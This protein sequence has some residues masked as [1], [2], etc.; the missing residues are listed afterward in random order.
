MKDPSRVRVTGPLGPYASG[1]RVELARQGYAPDSMAQRIQLVACLSRWMA[2]EKAAVSE[3]SPKL[4]ERFAAWRRAAGYGH[5]RSPQGLASLLAYLRALRAAPE[6]E[7]SRADG[8]IDVL[9]ERYRTYLLAERGL[10]VGTMRYYERFARLFLAQISA[11]G[12]GLDLARLTAGEVGRFVL[13]QGATRKVG[14]T[15]NMVMAVRSLLRFL[16]LDGVT[17]EDLEGAVPAVAPQPR[18]LPRAL[19]PGVVRR[20]LASCDRRTRTG[21]RDFAVLLVLTR[22]GL[23]AGEVA[24]IELEDIDWR[25][26]ELLVRSKGG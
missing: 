3:L 8:P 24:A 10:A 4:V 14:S 22:L 21:R 26:G 16:H 9:V 25:R 19:D 11:Q 18:P 20:L 12:R 1:F 7:V 23:R 15:K 13:E 6:P 5:F 2:A 17:A